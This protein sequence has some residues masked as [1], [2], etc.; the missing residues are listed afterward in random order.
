MGLAL[1]VRYAQQESPAVARIECPGGQQDARLLQFPQI[2]PVAFHHLQDL[3][4]G[5]A[6]PDDR[7]RVHESVLLSGVGPKTRGS[8]IETANAFRSQARSSVHRSLPDRRAT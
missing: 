2:A 7:D 8:S 5:L 3:L 4:E 1:L 6:I